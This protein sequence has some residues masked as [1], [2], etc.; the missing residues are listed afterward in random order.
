MN[1]GIPPRPGTATVVLG[2]VIHE[3]LQ[4]KIVADVTG[5]G[6]RSAACR[7]STSPRSRRR[8]RDRTRSRSA[9]SCT[10]PK[11]DPANARPSPGRR[12][13]VGSR[14]VA[15]DRA[16]YARLKANPTCSTRSPARRATRDRPRARPAA[17]AS[18]RTSTARATVDD[19]LQ[20]GDPDA[21]ASRTGQLL[22]A[23]QVGLRLARHPGHVPPDRRG[24]PRGA[25]DEGRRRARTSAIL[26]RDN[27]DGP[28]ASGIGG[29]LGWVAKGQ[30]DDR[31]TD[32]I[33]ATPIGKISEVVTVAGDGTY[34]FKVFA[35]ETR[36]PEGRQLEELT[37][38]AFSQVVRREEVGGARSLATTRPSRPT[39]TS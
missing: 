14:A 4:A 2:D 6:A 19:G 36:T 16:T 13:V 39:H 17:A 31:L 30:L 1:N 24:A 37:S 34:L 10:R 7:R 28:T 3:K 20:G 29:D 35:E 38:T 8:P 23:G 26:A 25:Q 21:R 33:F 12:P 27:S 15:G 11:D 5:P 9:T 32:A 18:C 22:D